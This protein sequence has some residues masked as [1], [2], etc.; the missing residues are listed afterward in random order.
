MKRSMIK[1]KQDQSGDPGNCST[2]EGYAK[3]AN[4]GPEIINF[5]EHLFLACL[6]A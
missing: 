2:A 1:N 6:A 3:N 4:P 5:P